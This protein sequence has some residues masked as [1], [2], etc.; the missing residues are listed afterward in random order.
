MPVEVFVGLAASLR[1]MAQRIVAGREY[2]IDV[3]GG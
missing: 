3:I 2:K 1:V